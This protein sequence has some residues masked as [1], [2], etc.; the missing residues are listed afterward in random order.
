MCP[1]RGQ[2]RCRPRS[3][4]TAPLRGPGLSR[5]G[6]CTA[7]T[8]PEPLLTTES[9]SGNTSVPPPCSPG[10][11]RVMTLV[12]WRS[13][14]PHSLRRP[15]PGQSM[16]R[17][18]PSHSHL[19]Q[20]W[21]GPCAATPGPRLRPAQW[22]PCLCSSVTPSLFSECLEAEGSWVIFPPLLHCLFFFFFFLTSS[23]A[24]ERARAR[25]CA[26]L[27]LAAFHNDELLLRRRPGKHDLRVVLQDVIQLLRGHVFQIA[28]MDHA[29]LGIPTIRNR[30]EGQPSPPQHAAHHQGGMLSHDVEHCADTAKQGTV[31]SGTSYY[32]CQVYWLQSIFIHV[33]CSRGAGLS[34]ASPHLYEMH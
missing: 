5:P 15:C 9:R 4:P 31:P 18:P 3:P 7:S 17:E 11:L 22:R 32:L 12:E 33:N 30:K 8:E 16:G 24:S 27:S 10:P 29:G 6:T 25:L 14:E 23:V 13:G 34:S 19:Q 28:S 1:E 26:D 20:R 21:L 2:R